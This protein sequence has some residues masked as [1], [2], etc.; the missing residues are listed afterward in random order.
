M[1]AISHKLSMNLPGTTQIRN[2][3]HP[4]RYHPDQLVVVI[5]KATLPLVAF[6]SSSLLPMTG[7]KCKNLWSWS[8]LSPSLTLSISYQSSL[9]ITVSVHSQSVNS[10]PTTSS[11]YY[12]LP[13]CSFAPQYVYLHILICTYITPVLMLS[14]NYFRLSMAYLLPYLLFYICTHCT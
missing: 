10:T 8:F 6:P 13:S 1:P 9:S 3:G 12:Y 7:T 5:P 11:P 14:C 2:H 4:L